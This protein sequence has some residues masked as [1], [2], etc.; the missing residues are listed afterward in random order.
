MNRTWTTD[1]IMHI[2]MDCFFVSVGLRKR[3]DLRGQPVA[4]TH[5]RAGQHGNDEEK[6]RNPSMSEIASC[7]YEARAKGVKNGMFL[8]TALNLCPELKT[9]PYDFEVMFYI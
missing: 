5:A 6:G 1:I 7:S 2:D 9:I 3:P 8:G 4:V